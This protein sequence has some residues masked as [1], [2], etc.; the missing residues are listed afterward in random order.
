MAESLASK[1][2]DAGSTGVA[3]PL[4][5]HL[6]GVTG[7]YYPV[8]HD[9][10]TELGGCTTYSVNLGASTNAAPVK[11]SPGQVY[12]VHVSLDVNGL[13]F[14]V[15]LYESAVAPTVG[16]TTIKRRLVFPATGASVGGR[17]SVYFNKGLAFATGIAVATTTEHTD[18]GTTALASA[19]LYTLVIDYK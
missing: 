3:I 6:D 16:T 13:A 18:A 19:T 14:C 7:Y 11:A 4:A 17:W 9:V 2:I 10:A 12:A 8:A 1:T 5:F 15:K